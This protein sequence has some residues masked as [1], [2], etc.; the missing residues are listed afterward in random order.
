MAAPDP[1]KVR[2]YNLE[3]ERHT[4]RAERAIADLTTHARHLQAN[5]STLVDAQRVA[6][7]ATELVTALSALKAAEDLRFLTE[8]A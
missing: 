4:K 2:G 6:A 3:V 1:L 5:A 7:A 8:E